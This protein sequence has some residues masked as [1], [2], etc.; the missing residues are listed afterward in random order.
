MQR[1]H[2]QFA[3]VAMTILGILAVILIAAVLGTLTV[4][5]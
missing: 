1:D 4:T 3:E 2:V 5:R